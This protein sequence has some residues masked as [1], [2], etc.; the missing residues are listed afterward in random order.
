MPP[1][2]TGR[3]LPEQD[4]VVHAGD[5]DA[6]GVGEEPFLGWYVSVGQAETFVVWVFAHPKHKFVVP[7]LAL[8]AV[9][10]VDEV[11]LG[12]GLTSKVCVAVGA[13]A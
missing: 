2:T 4:T 7:V 3:T 1:S 9:I 5:L 10:L 8:L 12:N 6:D 13:V 11:L